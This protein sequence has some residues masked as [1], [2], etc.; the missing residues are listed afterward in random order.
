MAMAA[1]VTAQRERGELRLEVRDAQGAT[2]AAT[3]EL[4]SQANQFRRMI[5]IEND[6]HSVAQDIPFG[7]YQLNLTASGFAPWSDLVEI[8]SANPVRISVT[9]GVAA[10][11]TQVQVTDA[12]TLVDPYRTGMLASI[13]R[14]SISETVSAQPGRTILT[15]INE[16]PG[17]LLE[18]NGTLHPRGAEYDV[19]YV[20]DGLPLTENR[21]PAFAPEFDAEEIESM[22]ILTASYPAEYGRKLGGVI[23]LTTQKDLPRGWH[24][25]LSADGGS[26]ST[27]SGS[28]ALSYLA[29][30]NRFS[31]SGDGLHTNRYLDPPVLENYTNR[32][33]GSGSSASYEREFSDHDRLRL[34]FTHNELRFM[35]PNELVQQEAGQRQDL[36]DRE[37]IGQ[38]Y[39]QHTISSD[40][41]LSFSGSVRDASP[42]LR[43]NVNSTPVIVAQDRG[44][45]Q[46]Y[47]RGDVAGHYGHHDWK[48][49]AD[50]IFNSV[51]EALEYTITDLT[52]FD[53][54]TNPHF[55]FPEHRKWDV[56]PAVYFQDE[57]HYGRWN[58]SAGVRFDHYSF[59]VHESAWSPRLG[60]SH[61]F[62][63]WNLLLHASYDRAFQTPAMENLLLASAADVTSLSTLVVR[64]PVRPSRGNYFETGF[65]KGIFGKLQL[66]GAVFRRDFRNYSDDDVLLDTGVSFPI[67]F[68]KARI[69]GEELKL[70]VPHWS[71]FSGFLSYSNQ[72]GIGQGPIT[73]G[74]FLGSKA[75]TVSD[76]GKFPV[77]QDQR[78]TA[79]FL[80]RYQAYKSLW[81]ATGAQ[82]GSGLPADVGNPPPA[83]LLTQ[84]GPE[85]LSRVNFDRGRV[86]PNFS[87][88]A[89]AGAELYRKEHRSVGF[90][91]AAANL[92]NRVNVINFAGLFSGTA[93]APP[94]SVSARL[95]FAF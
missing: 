63:R 95:R 71:R 50:S 60:L 86:R 29:G 18:A 75:G 51:H 24:G 46:G 66:D 34:T 3:A 22:R 5:Q 93:V 56:E 20:V 88:D 58:I 45:R 38:G 9:L 39:F 73:G 54:G 6:G 47:L 83:G 67:A 92:A 15:L 81:F 82:Y 28:A 33:N 85:I 90:Q 31:V 21:S 61:Y 32:A 57:A 27:A 23:E 43:S 26:F 25:Q 44:Y 77:T 13:G 76:T 30:K 62:A 65:T 40:L 55:L 79:R 52:S 2:L 11:N 37:S 4:I 89:A 49:G 36:S 12:A 70:Q 16:Q 35:T 84:Y 17:W 1:A 74:L 80:V 72:T 91:I 53:P 7:V 68:A 87:M 10:V 14:Q 94:R 64:L 19:Q 78:N 42:A 8:R 59:V 48:A 69:V 41:L